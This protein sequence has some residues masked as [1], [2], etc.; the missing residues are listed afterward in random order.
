MC[1]EEACERRVRQ[2]VW[3]EVVWEVYEW[4]KKR[5]VGSEGVRRVRG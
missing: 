1:E 4:I 3:W 5:D 2:S